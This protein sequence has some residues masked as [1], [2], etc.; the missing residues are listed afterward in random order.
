[1]N[2]NLPRDRIYLFPPLLGVANGKG[3]GGNVSGI[4][5]EIFRSARE[6]TRTD[7]IVVFCFC[8]IL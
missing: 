5:L 7:C 2:I 1:M 4:G 6:Q 8:L 3:Q